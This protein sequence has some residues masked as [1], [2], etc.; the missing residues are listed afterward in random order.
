[1]YNALFMYFVLLLLPHSPLPT[2]I[3]STCV[4]SY[5]YLVSGL[6]GSSTYLMATVEKAS[7]A[8]FIGHNSLNGPFAPARSA[9]VMAPV[10]AKGR[11]RRAAKKKKTRA[12]GQ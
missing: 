12:V 10:I 1:M 2:L 6:G 11:V 8:H 3:S 4:R 7:Y 5:A 9:L